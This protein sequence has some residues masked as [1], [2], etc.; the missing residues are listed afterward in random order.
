M[1][2]VT[3]HCDRSLARQMGAHVLTET[4]ERRPDVSVTAGT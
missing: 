3:N 1:T 4:L 2:Y